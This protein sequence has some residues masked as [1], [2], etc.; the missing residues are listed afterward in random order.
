MKR[1]GSATWKGGLREG[2]GS[3]STEGG[4]LE[5]HSYTFFSRYGEKP[6]TN[7]EELLGAAHAACFTMSFVRQLGKANFVPE[8]VDSKSE[9][10]IEK[11]GDGLLDA[12]S[13][14]CQDLF[15]RLVSGLAAIA[16]RD[17]PRHRDR[18]RREG[19]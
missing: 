9:I 19:I 15:D 7:P 13:T 1:F 4:A 12:E 3:V 2:N 16:G 8:H 5:N 6:G 14:L 18:G 17:A 11:D 10:T